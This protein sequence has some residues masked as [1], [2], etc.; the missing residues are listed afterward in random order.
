[1]ERCIGGVG[2]WLWF[3]NVPSKIAMSQ[4]YPQ[5]LI[6]DM[7]WPTLGNSLS[8]ALGLHL[9]HCSVPAWYLQRPE[10]EAQH[11]QRNGNWANICPHY[12]PIPEKCT[13]LIA[14]SLIS[15]ENGEMKLFGASVLWKKC[16]NLNIGNF[17]PAKGIDVYRW[18]HIPCTAICSAYEYSHSSKQ[19]Y[20]VESML[21]L[22]FGKFLGSLNNSLY[23][24]I[25]SYSTLWLLMRRIFSASI[26]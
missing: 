2:G 13:K 19:K 25:S 5:S 26:P 21:Y 18:W 23:F 17:R 14:K 24:L 15:V 1:M 3:K 7:P 4:F 20:K 16:I 22:L 8:L 11:V 12:L 6:L 10:C 9:F